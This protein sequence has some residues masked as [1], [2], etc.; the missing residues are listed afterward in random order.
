MRHA[1]S[2]SWRV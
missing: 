1:D 2:K